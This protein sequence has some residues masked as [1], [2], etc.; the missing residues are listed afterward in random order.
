M[1]EMQ[2]EMQKLISKDE[3]DKAFDARFPKEMQVKLHNAKVAI[4]GLGGLGS[5]IAVMLARSGVGQLLLVD[6]GNRKAMEFR[7]REESENVRYNYV[8]EL[9]SKLAFAKE[10]RTYDV[11]KFM[12]K[13]YEQSRDRKF[14]IAKSQMRMADKLG[15]GENFADA[16]MGNILSNDCLSVC[17][18][19]YND[20]ILYHVSNCIG[21]GLFN[22]CTDFE[23]TYRFD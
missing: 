20:F 17:E 18:W 8:L 11:E 23:N 12:R 21:R 4:A 16:M 14:A 13:R 7:Y 10:I 2:K 22:N 3:L 9:C 19:I 5:N 15:F 6:Y 1:T